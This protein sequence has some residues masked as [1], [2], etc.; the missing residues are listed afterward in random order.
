MTEDDLDQVLAIERAVFPTP[1]SLRSF[2]FE[3]RDNPHARNLVARV[4]GRV[5]A[6]ACIHVIAGDLRINNIAVDESS[7]RRGLGST[8]MSRLLDLGRSAGCRMA[9]LEVRPANRSARALYQRY[10][11]RDV[12]LRRG[13]YQDTGEDAILMEKDLST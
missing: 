2:R 8:L 3:L 6:Y 10:G 1:W 11:F 12:G 7:R 4:D 13:Y 5:R 9:S